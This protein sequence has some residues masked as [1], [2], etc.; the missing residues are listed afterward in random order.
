MEQIV[1]NVYQDVFT[2]DKRYIV[3]MGGRAA[4]RSYVASQFALAHLVAPEYFRAAIMRFVMG[5]IRNS[6][7]QEIKD[8]IE[9]QGAE[10]AI[11][12]RD[13]TLTLEY[14]DNKINGI[15]FRKSSSDQK[16][17]LKSLA[18]YTTV[19]IEEAEEV[20]E[21][22]FIQ[23]DDSLRT[24][25][26]D[27]RIVLLL[28]SPDK[29]HWI[30]RRWCNLVDSGIEGF[31]K[32]VLKASQTDTV[33][34]HTN[35][36][37]NVN[38]LNATTIRNFE[39]YKANNPDH[40]YN[41]IEGLVSEGARGRI[42]KNWLPI[43]DAEFEALPHPSY[44]GTDFGFSCLVGSTMV[45]TDVGEKALRDIVV[46]DRVLTRQGYKAVTST[47]AQGAKEV[48]GLDFGYGRSIIATG[49]HRIYTGDGWKTAE[50]LSPNETICVQKKSF[51][52][53]KYTDDTC[54]ENIP[55]TFSAQT[56]RGGYIATFISNIMGLYLK[57][58]TY[59]MW[60][61][62]PS[63]TQLKTW[64]P[65]HRAIINRLTMT[66][67]SV[68]S[69]RSVQKNWQRFGRSTVTQR[70]TGSNA[71]AKLWQQLN[72]RLRNVL[73]V[74]SASIP[75]TFIRS[76]VAQF[77]ESGSIQEIVKKNIP[78]RIVGLYSWGQPTT[79][80]THVL[81]RVQISCVPLKGKKE[82]FDISVEGASEFF[83]NGVLVH[84][85]D[86]AAVYEIKEHNDTIWARELVFETGLLNKHLSARMAQLGMSK[87]IINYAD[88]AEP[89]SIAE[90][91]DD[92]WYV[93]PTSKGAD[94][95]RARIQYLMG[96]QVY[97]TENSVNL[98]REHQ[99]YSW[100]LDRNKEPTNE[101]QDGDDH[102]IDAVSSAVWTAR[103]HGGDLMA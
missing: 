51:F 70:K 102:G 81:E 83:A 91:C 79:S 17:K 5:D 20:S 2:T 8:R 1:N 90:L 89:K 63:I 100:A 27:I 87:S 64:L 67:A 45:Q 33:F 69:R 86:P 50:Q 75:L 96:K 13:N 4:G 85:C 103:K 77:A 25:K 80:E 47:S 95:R 19:I 58:F 54:K 56:E 46:G 42:F 68:G 3:I 44:Y 92:G 28:N 49:D 98:A 35:Y 84:N 99:T 29:N 62:I 10:E 9:E 52:T 57:A 78:A 71:V 16:S 15:G 101:P 53:E 36:K 26:S 14:G 74:V 11:T 37:D 39:Q 12:I 93:V 21:E 72:L 82:V 40:Y 6:I 43:T 18:N 59:I 22:D 32:P 30:V 76:S 7:F 60:T 94:S 73:S 65:Y 88:A 38:N 61:L 66:L 31:F 55:N 23:L 41:M 34:I 97:Y 48:Y 24:M